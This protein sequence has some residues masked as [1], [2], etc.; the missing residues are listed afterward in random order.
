MA[1]AA[2][3]I[4]EDVLVRLVL[5]SMSLVLLEVKLRT[6]LL[7]NTL[8]KSG[9]GAVVALVRETVSAFSERDEVSHRSVPSKM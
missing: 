1:S 2:K 5:F 4:S 6:S 8:L 9:E 3:E 7:V